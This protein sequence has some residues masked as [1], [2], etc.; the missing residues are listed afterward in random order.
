MLVYTL[1]QPS[2]GVRTTLY[3][4]NYLA[5]FRQVY[6]KPCNEHYI[7]YLVTLEQPGLDI[8]NGIANPT[9]S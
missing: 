8:S 4:G 3:S 5:Q 9:V 1:L 6:Q 7:I 2:T